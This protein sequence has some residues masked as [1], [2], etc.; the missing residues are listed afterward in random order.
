M[1][2]LAFADPVLESQAH[3][4]AILRA[5]A[6][7]GSRQA[8]GEGLSPPGGLSP[9]AA[10]ALLTLVDFETP[11]WIAPTRPGAQEIA[12]YIGF[13]TGATRAGG[14]ERAVFALVGADSDDLTL[15]RYAQGTPEYPDRSTTLIVEAPAL[16]GGPR[17]QVAGPGVDGLAAFAPRGLPADF[18]ARW[19][20]N[21][22]AYPLGL[23]ILFCA[24]ASVAALPRSA[25]VS[26][27]A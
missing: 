5:L 24:G 13:H 17:L 26:G 1:S 11:W 7:P 25:R 21:H 3:F 2:A 8:C 9:A 23:D 18:V 20:T 6:S 14:P 22:A 27:A 15:S 10:A 16:E 19:A 4:R 12:T